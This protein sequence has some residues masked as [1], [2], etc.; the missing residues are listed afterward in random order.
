MIAEE[1][2]NLDVCTGGEL[3]VALRGRDA[4]GADRAC[5][6]TTSRSPS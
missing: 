3:A 5:T 2:L 1:G 4:A 6:A